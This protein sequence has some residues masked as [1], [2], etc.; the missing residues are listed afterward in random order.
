MKPWIHLGLA[1]AGALLLSCESAP[2]ERGTLPILTAADTDAARGYEQPPTLRASE[3]L[4]P[5]LLRGPHHEV[6]ESVATDGFLHL[7]EVSSPFGDFEAAGDAHL[8]ALVGEIEALAVLD[9][10][11]RGQAFAT[12]LREG[13]RMPF[14][15]AWNLLTD[16]IDSIRG[17]P[18]EAWERIRRTAALAKGERSELE[19]RELQAF[20]GFEEVKRDVAGRLGT[21][22]YSSNPVLQRALNRAAWAAYAGGVAFRWV[23]FQG[24][25]TP[26][27]MM[28]MASEDE[29][30]QNLLLHQAP[31]DL[32]RLNRIELAVMGVQAE[33]ADGFLSHP[34][35]SPR[36]QTILIASLV[37]LDPAADR[38]RFLEAALTARGE[39]DARVYQRIAELLRAIHE[40]QGPVVRLASEGKV[41]RAFLADGRRVTPIEVDHVVWT[42][43]VAELVRAG[44]LAAANEPAAREIWFTGTAS[45]KA[46]AEME[47][48]GYVVVEHGFEAAAR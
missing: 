43:P 16:P 11:S 32:R 5:E 7:Y 46:R 26:G 41:V 35:Y 39:A 3:L 30:L 1:A 27:P 44:T 28:P 29:R 42:W 18:T 47:D 4:P 25:V 14:V 48:L 19:E 31:E 36:H 33:L 12:G 6:S 8:R 40:G 38:A 17:V 21:D 15:A 9:E 2:T 22:P 37:A 20:L 45:A 13:L 34:W 23:P 10:I 24:A